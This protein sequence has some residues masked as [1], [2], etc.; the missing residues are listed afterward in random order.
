MTSGSTSLLTD[1]WYYGDAFHKGWNLIVEQTKGEID[2]M[3]DEIT[4][5]SK[6]PVIVKG[7]TIIYNADSFQNWS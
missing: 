4:I 2:N 3:L 5:V 1:P 6:M 7:D